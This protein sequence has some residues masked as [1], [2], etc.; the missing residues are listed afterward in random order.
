MKLKLISV[1]II[2]LLVLTV[3]PMAVAAQPAP[4]PVSRTVLVEPVY[5]WSYAPTLTRG[6]TAGVIPLTRGPTAGIITFNTVSGAYACIGI[7]HLA[8]NTEYWLGVY[9]HNSHETIWVRWTHVK[10]NALGQFFAGGKL[11]TEQLSVT[12]EAIHMG[13]VFGVFATPPPP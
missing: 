2:A 5:L 10:T 11:D 6:P 1:C 9:A 8:P 3:V 4:T 12:N 7:L 13:G